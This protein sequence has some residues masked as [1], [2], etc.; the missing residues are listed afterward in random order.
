MSYNFS[1]FLINQFKIILISAIISF[2]ITDLQAI[3]LVYNMKIRRVFKVSALLGKDPK[4]VVVLSA[5]PIVYKRDRHIVNNDMTPIDICE[6]RISAG[7]LLNLRYVPSQHWWA[8]VTTGIEKEHLKSH[9]NINPAASFCTSRSGFDDFVF[10][11]GHN[12]FPN[13]DVQFVLYGL[14]G[15]PS[16]RSVTLFDAQD[17]L[18]GTRFYTLGI[19]SELSYSFFN[20]PKQN[21]IFVFQNRFLHFFKRSLAPILPADAKVQPGNVTDL[22]FTLQYRV[23]AN[24]FEAGYNPTFFSDQAILLKTREIKSHWFV[25]NSAYASYLYLFKRCPGVNKPIVFGGGLSVAK[26]AKFDTKIFGAWLN[27]SLIF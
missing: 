18:V 22:L 11:A 13:E 4:P 12:W 14:G 6:K 17:A 16:K 3:S 15:L 24:L 27:L 10:S 25:R 7:S 26:S 2:I 21:L 23:K 5:V 19:G 8:E 1:K 20:R 9:S